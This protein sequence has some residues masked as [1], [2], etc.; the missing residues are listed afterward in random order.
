[1][2]SAREKD[3]S[4]CAVAP[5]DCIYIRT[6]GYK[7]PTNFHLSLGSHS[8]SPA[9]ATRLSLS[10]VESDFKVELSGKFIK[11]FES[12]LYIPDERKK[13]ELPLSLACT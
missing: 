2:L 7:S 13:E 8:S 10:L 5:C 11:P 3:S 4:R 9:S 6:N 12:A 1:M